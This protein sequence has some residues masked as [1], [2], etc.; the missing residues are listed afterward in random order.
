MIQI[1]FYLTATGEN[2][3][4]ASTLFYF[5]TF[6]SRKSPLAVRFKILLFPKRRRFISLMGC[7]D[8]RA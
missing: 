5:A 4:L 7:N 1:I 6:A 2:I 8:T 3:R